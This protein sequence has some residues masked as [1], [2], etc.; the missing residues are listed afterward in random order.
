MR[1]GLFSELA[2][3][4]MQSALRLF[5][6]FSVEYDALGAPAFFLIGVEYDAVG[7]PAFFSES[8]LN[9]MQSAEADFVLL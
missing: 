5:F 4:M 7:T 6:H 1:S 2:L 9:M 8:A 3:N